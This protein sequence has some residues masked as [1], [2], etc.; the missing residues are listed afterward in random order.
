MKRI[1]LT[2]TSSGIGAALA[3]RMAEDGFAVA[4]VDL[5]A[6]ACADVVGQIEEAGGTARAFAADVARE[7]SVA[8]VMDAV[9]AE[10][11]SYADRLRPMVADT[12]LELEKA[13]DARIPERQ[14][15]LDGPGMGEGGR[16]RDYGMEM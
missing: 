9:V 14:L 3:R 16:D 11:L 4:A 6:E 13:L 2:G 7:E 8:Q 12:S 15:R 5:S 10:L 1:W